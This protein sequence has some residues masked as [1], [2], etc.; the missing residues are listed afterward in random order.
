MVV[1]DVAGRLVRELRRGSREA[2]T[3][4]EPWDLRDTSG[5][6]VRSG[7]Y[8]VRLEADGER[9]VRPVMVRR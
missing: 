1:C 3:H 4:E 6:P 7:M 8:F 5:N 2:G 9:L